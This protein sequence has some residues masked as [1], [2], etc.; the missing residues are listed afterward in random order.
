MRRGCGSILAMMLAACGGGDE[1]DAEDDGTSTAGSPAGPEL[2]D[3]FDGD[4]DG[5]E[6]V[7][8]DRA[9]LRVA[10]GSLVIEPHAN[11][12][13]FNQSAGVLVAKRITG[14]FVVTAPAH[15]RSIADPGMP[16]LVPYRLGGLMA[17]NPGGSA[18]NYVFIVVGADLDDVS[19]ET[20]STLASQSAFQGPTW[21][22]GDAELRICREGGRFAMLV[23][24]IGSSTWMQQS[25][26][27]RSDLPETLQV[28][29]IAYANA[30]P[31]DLRM[32]FDA[33][34]FTAFAGDCAAD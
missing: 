26:V 21:P 28:G 29:F 1:S 9:D 33:V 17:R 30:D 18:E 15:A 6:I 19:I 20:K 8:P 3:E 32:S 23:R 14:D 10:D 12:L 4:L 7:N 11:S 22:S 34:H 2:D 13:W 16:P 31:A 24:E 27:T 5:W 25:A